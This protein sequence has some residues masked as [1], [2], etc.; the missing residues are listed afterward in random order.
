MNLKR[1]H[2]F[3]S[4]FYLRNWYDRNEKI[5]VWDG[6]K[7]FSSKSESIGFQRDLYKLATLTKKQY[8]LLDKYLENWEL[9]KSSIYELSFKY[10]LEAQ[11]IFRNG[12][13]FIN[14]KDLDT[15]DELN[16]I[17]KE[18]STNIVEERLSRQ[19]SLF[20][21]VL[22]KL[23][24]N[25]INMLSLNDYNYLVHFIVF[26]YMKTPKKIKHLISITEESE[27]FREANF[28]N[29][30]YRTFWLIFT[31]C[32]QERVYLSIFKQ[33][34]TIKI[35]SNTSNINFITSDDP[36]F[37][38]RINENGFLIQLPISPKVMIELAPNTYDDD[39]T[40]TA[41]DYYSLNSDNAHEVFLSDS[42]VTFDNIEEEQVIDLNQK[43]FSNRDRFIYAQQVDDINTLETI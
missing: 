20:S 41:V 3:V 21:Q 19:E 31:Q 37:N 42:F 39:F 7:K 15:I 29:E 17:E 35:Y 4:Q 38:Q 16:S 28:N 13:K 6:Y 24:S 23:T 22:E 34:Y 33:L 1:K 11:S 40:K 8:E 25:S 18:F 32:F 27:V 43:I 5:I 10:I 2:H 30:Q 26:Q 12:F 14:P 36:C 9:K